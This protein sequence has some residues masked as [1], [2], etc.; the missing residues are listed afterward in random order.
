MSIPVTELTGQNLGLGSWPARRANLAPDAIAWSFEGTD[1][2]F[3]Q[4]ERRVAW[5]AAALRARGVNRGDRI[6]Y[7]G[8]NHPALLE[9]LFAAG[10][11]GAITV[12][13]NARLARAEVDYILRDSGAVLLIHGAEDLELIESLDRSGKGHPSLRETVLVDATAEAG[14]SSSIGFEAL[15]EAGS[16]A[17]AVHV[18][19]GLDDP[20]LIM[21]TSGTTGKPK[22]AVLTHG[23]IFFNNVNTLIE[24]DLGNDEVCLAVAPLFHIAGLNTPALPVFLKGG[25]LVIH[26]QFRPDTAL[27]AIETEHITCMFGVPAMLDALQGHPRFPDADLTTLRTLIVGGSPVPERIL[28]RFS[29]ERGVDIQQGYGLTETASGVLKLAATDAE[30]KIGSTGKA[31]FLV[32]VRVVDADGNDVV[33]GGAGEILTR[34][35]SVFRDYWNQPDISRQSFSG[36]WFRTGDVATVDEEGYVYLRDRSKDMFISGGENIYPSE[37]ETA[38]LDVEGVAEAAVI[39]VDDEK[40]GEVGKAFVVPTGGTALDADRVLGALD[41]RLA[42]YKTPKFLEIVDELPRNATG[43]L[44]KHVLR[45]REARRTE[46]TES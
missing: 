16:S 45:S 29:R 9:T 15:L 32:D 21:Y 44:Q 42:R 26:R 23:N 40:W 20:C 14:S 19:V 33:A 28:R 30:R 1:T 34:G 37:V 2:S 18:P 43:K 22:G 38:L 36:G 13:I 41:G 10:K 3:G 31:Q 46:G 35:P 17:E 25:R 4:V 12:L 6:A 27:V 39:G 8:S 24:A 7:L 11:I 5:L